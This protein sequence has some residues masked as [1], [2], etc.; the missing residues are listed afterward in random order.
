MKIS[1]LLDITGG[2]LLN[3]P[4]ISFTYNIKTNPT[5]VKDGDLFIVLN[6]NDIELAVKN[7]AFCIVLEDFYPIIDN[8]IAWIKVEDIQKSIIKIVRFKLS[9]LNINAYYCDNINYDLLKIFT[10]NNDKIF[11]FI[12]INNNSFIE[13]IENIESGDTIFCKNENFLKN[14]YPTYKKFSN[15]EIKI[16][17]LTKHSLFESSFSYENHFFSRVKI[18]E[19][20]IKN[21]IE[22]LKFLN[23]E[24]ESSKIKNFF[25]LKPIFLTKNFEPIEYGKS[26]RFI[27]C[28]DNEDLI[29]NEILF[30]KNNYNYGKIIFLTKKNID[31]LIND[32]QFIIDDLKDL[33]STI[34]NLSFNALYIFGFSYEEILKRLS[35]QETSPSLFS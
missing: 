26:D 5:K 13:D 18:S 2:V 15:E 24:I 32:N 21:F 8:E 14:I 19:I 31:F 16:E 4:S 11:K 23:C 10:N 9:L 35:T 27:I 6:N 34:K 17:N 33:K 28:Q 3:T 1:A 20:Y 29:K 22:V 7:G 30:I 25:H 12:D